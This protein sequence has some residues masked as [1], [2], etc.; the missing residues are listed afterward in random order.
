MAAWYKNIDLICS[1]LENPVWQV[2]DG[3]P[4]PL[5]VAL[6]ARV[7]EDREGARGE[8]QVGHLQQNKI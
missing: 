8:G 6:N 7:V 3:A 4:N 5:H 2:L 1:S